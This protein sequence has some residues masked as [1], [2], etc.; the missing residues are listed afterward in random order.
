MGQEDDVTPRRR[1]KCSAA[2]RAP[3][4]GC[5]DRSLAASSSPRAAGSSRAGST[6]SAPLLV[7]ASLIA[8]PRRSACRATASAAP[9]SAQPDVAPRADSLIDQDDDLLGGRHARFFPVEIQAARARRTAGET[10]PPR[11]RTGSAR[12][13]P[14]PPWSRCRNSHH[15]AARTTPAGAGAAKSRLPAGSPAAQSRRAGGFAPARPASPPGSAAAVAA[16]G[17]TSARPGPRPCR[18]QCRISSSE[19]ALAAR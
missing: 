3:R 12:F 19:S 15:L 6:T 9:A 11:V 17:S 18:S 5:G 16:G 14:E 2:A 13:A 8:I 1:R 4:P 7:T 10:L